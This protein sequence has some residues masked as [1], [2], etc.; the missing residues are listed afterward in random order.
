M[1]SLTNST[2]FHLEHIKN[3]GFSSNYH[4]NHPFLLC[5]AHPFPNFVPLLILHVVIM[6]KFYE[7]SSYAELLGIPEFTECREIFLRAWWGPFL[8]YLQGHDDGVSVQF[9]LRFDG[10]M[11]RVGSLAFLFSKES[12]ASTMKFPWVGD[13]WFKHHQ[14]LRPSYNRVLRTKYQYSI[15]KPQKKYSGP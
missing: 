13:H 5:R 1:N 11:A 12:I 2:I 3:R 10:R 14:F 15:E 7:P 6:P 9:T 4:F 8:A